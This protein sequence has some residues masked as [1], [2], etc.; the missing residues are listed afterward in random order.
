ME[1]SADKRFEGCRRQADFRD[2]APVC[3]YPHV[4]V[5]PSNA[6][7]SAIEWNGKGSIVHAHQSIRLY[8]SSYHSAVF[9]SITHRFP[10]QSSSVRMC[11]KFSELSGGD[12]RLLRVACKTP[13]L[14]ACTMFV[15]EKHRFL[16]IIQIDLAPQQTP[17]GRSMS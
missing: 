1:E 5:A 14:A 15:H 4:V 17:S 7:M 2:V 10:G 16:T 11:S 12:H 6:S 3:F 8:L 13:L 9:G